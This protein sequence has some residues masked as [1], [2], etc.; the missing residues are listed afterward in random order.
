MCGLDPVNTVTVRRG[1]LDTELVVRCCPLSGSRI[2]EPQRSTYVN[3][4]P[5]KVGLNLYRPKCDDT[6]TLI[7]SPCF[8]YG[9]C[10]FVHAANQ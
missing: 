4:Q 9:Y 8:N 5:I 7:L 10:A 1:P 3:N 2:T 6:V